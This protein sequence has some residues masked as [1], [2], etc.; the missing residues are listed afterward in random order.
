MGLKKDKE[1][2]Y[3]EYRK[4]PLSHTDGGSKQVKSATFFT[5]KLTVIHLELGVLIWNAFLT[6]K[7]HMAACWMAANKYLTFRPQGA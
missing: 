6:K 3:I 4:Y 5:C 7:Y 2:V 1:T